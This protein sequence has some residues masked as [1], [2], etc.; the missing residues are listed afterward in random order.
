MALW[1]PSFFNTDKS[2]LSAGAFKVS[3]WH[4]ANPDK[5]LLPTEESRM[6]FNFMAA[7]KWDV[8]QTLGTRLIKAMRHHRLLGTDSTILSSLFRVI[9]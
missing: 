7:D 1:P 9:R 6:L 8:L 5:K 3:D 4:C 2:S